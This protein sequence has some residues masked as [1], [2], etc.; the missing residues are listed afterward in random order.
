MK[1]NTDMKT[2]AKFF[3]A[4]L[5]ILLPA[6]V[7]LF[8]A[9]AG[10]AQTTL[11]IGISEEPRTLNVWKATDANSNKVLS[12]VYQPLY[13]QDPE[14]LELT[15]WLA[16]AM[17]SWD[18]ETLC[19][20]MELRDAKWADG[21]PVTAADVVFTVDTIQRF[22]VPKYQSEWSYVRKVEA[23]GEKT[24]RF[25]L[26]EPK[27]T[28]TTRT[29]INYVVP[30]KQ[31]APLVKKAEK[32]EKPLAALLNTRIGKPLGCGP[33]VLEQWQEG[34]FIYL[35]KNPHFF[36]QGETINN[37]LLG[38]YVDAILFKVYGTADVAVL[39]LKKG[40]IDF[41]WW[42]IQPGYLAGLKE[43]ENIRVYVSDKSALY[44]MGFNVRKAPFSDPALRQAAAFVI[45]KEFIVN[46]I[47]QGYAS[48]M[49]SIIPTENKYWHAP[50][51]PAYGRGMTRE[52]RIREAFQRLSDAGYTWERPP[53]TGNANVVKPSGIIL[54]NGKPM[55]KFTI[56]T[57]P[58]DYDPNRATC[59]IMIQEWLNELGIPA[60]AR[61]MSFGALLEKVKREHD[62]DT[63]ILGYGRLSLDPDYL[64]SFFHSK[65]DKP[66]G[67]NM[68]GYHNPGF[69]RLAEASISE[70]DL[71]KRRELVYR[72]QEV[73][74]ADVPYIPL[75]NPSAIEAVAADRF[76]GW[77]QMVGGIGNLWSICR[78]KPK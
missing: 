29:L 75:Y 55:E 77:E 11:K 18:P 50:D 5:V 41:L 8:A 76:S 56:L 65:N 60:S 58:A 2:R 35:K 32:Q 27:A 48:P 62:F 59:G 45:D 9:G 67:W 69:D 16:K 51:L 15:P 66:G 71:E 40:E 42:T 22:Q 24:V 36:G 23:A 63:F 28:F 57:P 14:T 64:R 68:S 3:A 52:Q 34:N 37:R 38:P 74:M 73:I 20:T 46:R 7:P 13:I 70:M 17:P 31:W 10:A 61:P 78:V 19:Y 49:D 39:A 4:A 33:F 53:V 44:Y 6:V 25:Y 21:S 47:L 54:P 43:D 1:G 12:L 72:M 26:E 30:E